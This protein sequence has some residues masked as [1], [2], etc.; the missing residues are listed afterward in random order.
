MGSSPVGLNEL[1]TRNLVYVYVR[2][3]TIINFKRN[4]DMVRWYHLKLCIEF[5][6]LNSGDQE[7]HMPWDLE[8]FKFESTDDMN[9]DVKSVEWHVSKAITTSWGSFTL[10]RCKFYSVHQLESYSELNDYLSTQS[11]QS[12]S[13][14]FLVKK[15]FFFAGIVPS[16]RLKIGM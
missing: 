3:A 6:W 7:I 15:T 12:R 1:W 4:E 9:N 11:C 5:Q 8:T 13:S 16:Q 14:V 2:L 10:Q